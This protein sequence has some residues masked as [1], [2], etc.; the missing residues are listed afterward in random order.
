MIITENCE[1]RPFNSFG[2][3]GTAKYFVEVFSAQEIRDLLK[4]DSF[5]KIERLVIGGGSNMLLKTDY[6][7]CIIAN[8]ITGIEIIEEN[9]NH[10]YIKAGA[11]IVW[12]DLVMHCISNNYA[13]IE[14]LS[15]IPGSVGAS[16][17]Q[18]IG[19]YGVELKDVFHE[20]EAMELETMELKKFSNTDCKFGYRDSVFKW[21]LKNKFII[22]SVTLRLNKNPIY[23]TSYGAIEDELTNMGI[24]EKSIAAISKAVCNI[25]TSKLPNPAEIGNAGSFF[26][27]PVI[28]REQYSALKNTFADMVSYPAGENVK[29][30][31]GWLIEQCGWKG[32]TENNFGVHK[33]QALVLVN[34]GGASGD[35]IYNLSEKIIK[36]VNE[37][38][39]V[40]LERE[41]NVI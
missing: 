7:G 9:D 22:C 38:F 12:H 17:I 21:H 36:S 32:Y 5:S 31:A 14:N 40:L 20:L 34:Y 28:G 41:V 8:R 35:D 1:L 29:L 2:I 39:G 24:K 11:G 15:L 13:G 33:N 18:N 4:S 27:N 26:K 37:K 16:P 23:N 10:V 19:A 25:R 30:A 3:S 6:K